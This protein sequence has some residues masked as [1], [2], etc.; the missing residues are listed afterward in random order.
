[1]IDE[2][3]QPI[4]RDTSVGELY[5]KGPAMMLGYLNNPAA[6]SA[7]I[8]GD[9]WLRTGDVGYCRE[10]KWYIVDRKKVTIL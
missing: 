9:G 8:T 10:S 1:M 2:E 3:G 4:D 7:M 6:S 5:V